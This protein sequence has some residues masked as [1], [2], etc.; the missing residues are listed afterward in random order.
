MDTETGDVVAYVTRAQTGLL[1]DFDALVEV[2]ENN[3]NALSQ[4]RSGQVI[5]GGI[6]PVDSLRATM[7]AMRQFAVNMRRSANVG[8][9]YAYDAAHIVEALT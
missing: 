9:G 7:A 5:I 3:V 1:K 4:Q 2:L 6:D 8:I